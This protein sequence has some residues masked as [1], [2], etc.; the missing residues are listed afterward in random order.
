MGGGWGREMGGWLG[1]LAGTDRGAPRPRGDLPGHEGLCEKPLCE[2]CQGTKIK[3][4][5]GTCPPTNVQPGRGTR[6]A[7]HTF[8]LVLL[9]ACV[10][11]DEAYNMHV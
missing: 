5:K 10:I 7:K 6:G 11:Y 4:W 8:A 2:P 9:L 1:E 3:H